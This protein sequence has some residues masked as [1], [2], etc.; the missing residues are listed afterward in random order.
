[1]N[2]RYELN[3][4]LSARLPTIR[5]G[6]IMANFSWNRANR[7]NGIVGASV[8]SVFSPTPLNMKYVSGDPIMP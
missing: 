5:A 6:V 1:M 2:R 8:A 7:R 4:I 3:R